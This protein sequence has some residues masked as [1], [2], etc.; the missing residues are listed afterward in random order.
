MI[1]TWKSHRHHV[2]VCF[3]GANVVFAMF[4]AN[5]RRTSA[6][7]GS[8]E[9]SPMPSPSRGIPRALLSV[10]TRCSRVRNEFSGEVAPN[11]L[12]GTNIVKNHYR[13]WK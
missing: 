2:S 11:V 7:T 4:L 13:F 3:V 8:A 10:D 9:E 5:K 12:T 6:I 1:R